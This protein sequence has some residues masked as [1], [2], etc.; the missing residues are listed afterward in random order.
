MNICI[1]SIWTDERIAHLK[2][3]NTDGLSASLIAGELGG[4][5]SRNAVIGKINRLGIAGARPIRTAPPKPRAPR[6]PR[7]RVVRAAGWQRPQPALEPYIPPQPVV[8]MDIPIEQRCTLFTLTS[9]TCRWPVGDP[10][11]AAFFF[12]GDPSADLDKGR[13]YCPSHT[14]RATQRRG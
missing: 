5:I 11:D 12:C 8:D 4:G 10:D 9:K 2:R 14:V 6:M 1:N 13:P 3:L 7:Q